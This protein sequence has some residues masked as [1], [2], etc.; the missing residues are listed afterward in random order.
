MKTNFKRAFK[1]LSLLLA[2]VVLTAA[3]QEF[4]FRRFDT[5]QLIVD[6]FY[7]EEENTL[8]IALIGASEFTSGYAPGLAYEEYGFRSYNFAPDSNPISLFLY[9][10][11]EIQKTQNPQIVF[12]EINGALYDE[13]GA[14][15]EPQLRRVL[16]CTPISENKI[17]TIKHIFGKMDYSYLFPIMK[18]HYSTGEYKIQQEEIESYNQVRKRGYSL[19]KGMITNTGNTTE[20]EAYNMLDFPEKA[21]LDPLCEKYLYEFLDYC[22]AQNLNVVFFRFPQR[23]TEENLTRALRSK[24]AKDIIT[25]YGFEYFDFLTNPSAIGIDLNTH[26]YNNEH[27]NVVGQAIMTRKLCEIAK[28]RGVVATKVSTEQKKRWDETVKYYHLFYDYAVKAN[29]EGKAVWMAEDAKT[30]SLIES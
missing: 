10:L 19:L 1:V 22:K 21:P 20:G 15:N 27:L 12:V 8:D 16:D 17:D 5:M 9:E 13:G 7:K 2:V 23:V 28:E 6:G 25:S 29:S 18:Y 4:V 11:K 24:T 26:F 30:L 3:L 14:H